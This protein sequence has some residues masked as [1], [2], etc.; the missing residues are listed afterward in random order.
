M[1][2]PQI[3]PKCQ[4]DP[5]LKI[6]AHSWFKMFKSAD[7]MKS[8][9]CSLCEPQFGPFCANSSVKRFEKRPSYF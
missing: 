8:V 2:G 6:I 5:R 7:R 1:C 3:I 9:V 4:C